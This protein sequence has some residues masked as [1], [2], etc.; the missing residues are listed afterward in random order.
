MSPA[1]SNI[2][3]LSLAITLVIAQNTFPPTPLVSKH[4]A[5][6]TGIVRLLCWL[7]HKPYAYHLSLKESTLTWVSFVEPNSVII[8]VTRPPKIKTRCVKPP[9]L[10]EWTVRVIKFG[11][12]VSLS[13]FR[14]LSMGAISIE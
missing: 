12:G 8:S 14:L 5:Y 9:S 3:P 7:S 10:M 13:L 6:P 1:L 2:V 11:L 4:F